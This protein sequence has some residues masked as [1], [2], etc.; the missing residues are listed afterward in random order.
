MTAMIVIMWGFGWIWSSRI[1]QW[2]AGWWFGRFFIFPYLGNVIIP[3]DFHS[4]IFQRGW[5]QPATSTMICNP[6]PLSLVI[7]GI[8][9]PSDPMIWLSSP[10][11]VVMLPYYCK[12]PKPILLEFLPNITTEEITIRLL[13]PVPVRTGIGPGNLKPPILG[14]LDLEI[15]RW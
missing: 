2:S 1:L 5:N 13:R 9:I 4:M 15:F 12:S 10:D 6:F 11:L 7:D 14:W 8:H 3:T